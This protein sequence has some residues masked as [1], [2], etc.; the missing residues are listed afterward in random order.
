MQ[1]TALNFILVF[2][3]EDKADLEAR[4]IS[5]PP[6]WQGH[7]CQ[8]LVGDIVRFGGKQYVVAGRSWEYTLG[9]P[10]LCLYMSDGVTQTHPATH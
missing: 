1:P 10:S 4:G 9:A 7:Y 6:F 2:S 3:P 8:P 5:V